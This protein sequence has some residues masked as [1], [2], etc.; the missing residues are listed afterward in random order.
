MQEQDARR[1]AQASNTRGGGGRGEGGDEKHATEPEPRTPPPKTRTEHTTQRERR[2][3][4]KK[5]NR[6]GSDALGK[7]RMKMYGSR[8]ESVSRM[9]K[10]KGNPKPKRFG[11]PQ[12]LRESEREKNV[13]DEKSQTKEEDGR[14]QT[15]DT[16][17]VVKGS[18]KQRQKT[19]P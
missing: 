13:A 2:E 18:K 16:G 15:P 4:K 9:Q 5:K 10:H 7:V 3:K 14:K 6:C 8:A 1:T 19:D 17:R 12:R 11:V